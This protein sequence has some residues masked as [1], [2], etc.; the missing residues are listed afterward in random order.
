MQKRFI[1][2]PPTSVDALFVRLFVLLVR[3]LVIIYFLPLKIKV[4]VN[5]HP[6]NSV[7]GIIQ[8]T[9]Q[10]EFV[11]FRLILTLLKS[12]LLNFLHQSSFG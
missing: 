11:Y 5:K 1:V 4:V 2:N 7:D 9:K 10:V 8:Y 3:L 6:R 12:L